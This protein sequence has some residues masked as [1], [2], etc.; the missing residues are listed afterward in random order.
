[1]W[2]SVR[3]IWTEFNEP[4]EA[5]LNFMYLDVKGLVT[6]GLGNLIDATGPPAPR[7]PTDAERAASHR[8]GQRMEWRDADGAVADPDQVTAEW[9]QI[10]ERLDQ[11]SRGGGTFRRFATLFLPDEEIDRIVVEKLEEMESVLRS[12]APFA[13]FDGFPADAQLG[14]LSMA[15]GMGPAFRFP[16]FQGFVDMG[17]WRAAAD[18]CRFQPDIGTIIV[19]NDRN[20]AL[21]RNAAAV[22]EN[23]WDRDVL[24]W[25]DEA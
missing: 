18:E 21:F 25:P 8:L 23:D 22:V 6:T 20:Q 3:E 19:R 2:Q 12:R 7:A 17:D 16:Q 24:L 13:A 9:D 15:W 4:L 5:R 1:M 14:L 11:A 10:K